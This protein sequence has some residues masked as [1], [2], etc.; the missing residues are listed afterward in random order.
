M[1]FLE[2][3]KTEEE[4][5]WIAKIRKVKPEILLLELQ[6]KLDESFIVSKNVF[7]LNSW[8]CRFVG[9]KKG[10]NFYFYVVL[11]MEMFYSAN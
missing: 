9:E 2:L 4:T 5:L 8:I 1:V 10:I 7:R 11:I 6:L 3:I